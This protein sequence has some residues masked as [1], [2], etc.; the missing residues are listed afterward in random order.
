MESILKSIVH[1]LSSYQNQNTL[2]ETILSVLCSHTGATAGKWFYSD[3]TSVE[4]G[5]ISS[6]LANSVIDQRTEE[7]EL[8]GNSLILRLSNQTGNGIVLFFENESQANSVIEYL[9]EVRNLLAIVDE[10]NRLQSRQEALK[11][12]S[13]EGV[14]LAKKNSRLFQQ[15]AA[16]EKRMGN[17]SRGIIRMQ[18]EERARISRDLHDGVGQALLALKMHLDM[19]L[20]NP[21]AS[22]ERTAEARKLTEQTLEEVRQLSRLLRPPM[23]DDLGLLPTL[24]SYVKAYSE[25]TGIHASLIATGIDERLDPDVE[26]MLF[27]VTQEGLNNVLKHSDAKNVTITISTTKSRILFELSDDGKGFVASSPSE[28]KGSGIFG[29][30]DRVTLLGGEFSIRSRPSAGVKIR[31]KIPKR[32]MISKSKASRG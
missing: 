3:S 10:K 14:N 15:L 32:K 13:E 17:I 20:S 9:R 19:I 4:W 21:S 25:R 18:E 11:S 28:S 6:E 2:A 12:I 26:T 5:R 7:I 30:R 16:N 22:Q 29:M 1:C 31:I 23:L 27:R 24:R 8:Q